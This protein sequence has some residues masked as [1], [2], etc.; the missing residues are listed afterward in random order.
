MFFLVAAIAVMLAIMLLSRVNLIREVV[1][2]FLLAVGMLWI[3]GNH[4][5]DV[6]YWAPYVVGVMMCG[7]A[8]R[9]I[10]TLFQ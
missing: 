8:I 3:I 1:T 9:W 2:A 4:G 10:Y 5:G 7:A 6:H